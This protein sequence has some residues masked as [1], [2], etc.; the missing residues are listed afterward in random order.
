MFFGTLINLFL[1]RDSLPMINE[2]H[3]HHFD[4]LSILSA[5]TLLIICLN[6]IFKTKINNISKEKENDSTADLSL[7]IKGMTCNH[8]KE[9]AE[10]AIN[11]CDNVEKLKINLESGQ[12]LIYG[13]DLVE[14]DI[15]SAINNSGFS[16]GK[17]I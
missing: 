12:A 5:V 8:C 15:I 7:I 13:S 1:N 3:H 16:V 11:S 17:N 10:E 6:A 9:T 14:E 4:I 2:M